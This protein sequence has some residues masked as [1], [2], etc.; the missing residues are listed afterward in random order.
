MRFRKWLVA[1]AV[2]A[3]AATAQAA[4]D[5]GDKAPA[6]KAPEWMNLPEGLKGLSPTD[7]KGRVVMV[8][9]WATW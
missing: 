1:I 3:S 4:P 2:M 9:F 8:E 7:L 6:I 5:E